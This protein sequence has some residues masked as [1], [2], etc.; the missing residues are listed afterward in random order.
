MVAGGCVASAAAWRGR[1]SSGGS[2]YRPRTGVLYSGTT[3]WRAPLATISSTATTHRHRTRD[4][5]PG[6]AARHSSWR[7]VVIL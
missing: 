6:G 5:E 3:V 1:N 4:K 2:S 7:A